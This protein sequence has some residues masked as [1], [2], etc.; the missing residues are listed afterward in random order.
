MGTMLQSIEAG[1][2]ITHMVQTS[3]K[4]SF[5]NF[6]GENPSGW[7]YKCDNFLKINGIEDYEKVGLASLHL[8][9]R[10][11]EWFQGYEASNKELNWA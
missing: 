2:V 11:L 4:P 8:E 3:F 6:L 5:P 10:A 1:Q 7:I 9:G